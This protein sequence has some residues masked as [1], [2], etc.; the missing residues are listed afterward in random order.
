M[1][2]PILLHSLDVEGSVYVRLP[3]RGPNMCSHAFDYSR[4]TGREYIYLY[5]R[6]HLVVKPYDPIAYHRDTQKC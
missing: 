2:L 5:L 1:T 3:T 6:E 4:H